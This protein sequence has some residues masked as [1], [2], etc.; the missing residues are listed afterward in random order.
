MTG[1]F[2]VCFICCLFASIHG[3]SVETATHGV[4]IV[5]H[6]P[7]FSVLAAQLLCQGQD[8]DAQGIYLYHI[9]LHLG[10]KHSYRTGLTR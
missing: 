1:E 3:R 7:L 8:E 9:V 2:K 10:N 6:K 4:Q 5:G